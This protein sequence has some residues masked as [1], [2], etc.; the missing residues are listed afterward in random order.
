[1]RG[2]SRLDL[3]FVPFPSIP[4]DL[5]K[6]I[7]IAEDAQFTGHNGIDFS[8]L[9]ESI[10]DALLDFSLPR[11]ASTITQQL[12]KNLYLSESYNPLRKVKE[13]LVARRLERNLSKRRIFE[14]YANLIE[15][16]PHI[17]GVHAA[18]EYYFKKSPTELTRDNAAFLAAIIPSPLGAFN[19]KRNA[20]RVDG[21]KRLLLRRM[22][23]SSAAVDF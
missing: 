16:G 23:I 11:G 17:Y 4:R 1:M 3:K 18:S 8:E 5:R 7:I 19:P 22:D 12:A 15:W 20:A 9:W 10:K 14:L 2:D 21:R 6:A 13:Y